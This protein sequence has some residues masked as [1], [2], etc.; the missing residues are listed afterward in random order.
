MWL[1]LFIPD[2][3][4]QQRKG[5]PFIFCFKHVFAQFEIDHVYHETKQYGKQKYGKGYELKIAH[6]L[7]I[8][9][10]KNAI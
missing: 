2:R 7:A 1:V 5:Y 9:R 3:L 10:S 8:T 6:V 4:I